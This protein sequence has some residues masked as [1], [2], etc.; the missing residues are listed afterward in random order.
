MQTMI[1]I[2]SHILPGV[3]DGS[4]NM[5]MTRQMLRIA[6]SEGIRG[7]IATPHHRR[8]YAH[9]PAEKLREAYEAVRE[10]ARKMDPSFQV[11]LGSELFVSHTLEEDLAEGEALSMAGTGYVMVEFLPPVAYREIKSTMQ[12]LRMAGYLPI[13]AHAERYECLLRDPSLT[14]DLT[15]MGCYIQINSA[16]VTGGNGFSA[17]RYV[18]KLLKYDLVHFL[19]SDAHDMD[20]R[21]PA[22]QKSVDYIAKRYGEGQARRISWENPQKLLQNLPV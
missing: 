1:D 16:S 14:E 2:H 21:S 8:G 7:M 22:M 3:D 13:V 11:Y 5:D 6:W 4:K 10:E 17:K 19:G 12:R 9:A 15:D 20:R 18:K